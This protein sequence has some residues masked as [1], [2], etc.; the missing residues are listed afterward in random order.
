MR[1]RLVWTAVKLAAFGPLHNRPSGG[2]AA[3][4]GLASYAWQCHV[5]RPCLLSRRPSTGVSA[6]S[7]LKR[8][9]SFSIHHIE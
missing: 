9:T 3:T 7:A 2:G 6:P 4:A 1:V 5:A 8:A